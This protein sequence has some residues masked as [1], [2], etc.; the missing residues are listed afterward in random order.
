VSA[1]GSPL[2]PADVERIAQLAH[3]ALAGA[4]VRRIRSDRE[5]ERVLVITLRVPGRTV[6]LL[7]DLRPGTARVHAT[8]TLPPA[9]GSPP[10]FVQL[11][12][13]RLE[14]AHLL[15]VEPVAGDRTLR[16]T[17]ASTEAEGT[18][19]IA[20]GVTPPC[21][22]FTDA[23][24]VSRGALPLGATLPHSPAPEAVRRRP[25]RD[26]LTSAAD[27]E[28]ASQRLAAEFDPLV[29]AHRIQRLRTL[30]RRIAHQ[31]L[32]RMRRRL[33]AIERDIDAIGAADTLRHEAD[34]LNAFRA[35]YARGATTLTLPDWLRE[36][37]P[38]VISLDP[39]RPLDAQI[40]ARYRRARRLARG[41]EIA[42]RRH[43]AT[44]QS[45]AALE[46][47][48]CEVESATQSESLAPLLER[49]PATSPRRTSARADAAPARLPWHTFASS[50]GLP[51][52]VG[53]SA[54]D[55]DRLT[56]QQARGNDV[57][58]HVEDHTGSHVVIRAPKGAQ[59]PRRTLE[60]AALLAAHY[61]DARGEAVVAVRWT[62]RKHVRKPRG[63]PPGAV[64]VAAARTI[65]IRYDPER[66]ETLLSQGREADPGM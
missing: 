39:A 8:E 62:E 22:V 11:L 52:L 4:A 46:Q 16:L 28:E 55:N 25:L 26:A 50:D 30:A 21:A 6:P 45:I 63:A 58:L 60:E 36:N 56:F 15:A 37:E 23:D 9:P 42:L 18:L 66:L 5:D 53:R 47:I 51:I 48:L 12:R 20:L 61:S 24:G 2:S 34:L 1:M 29:E 40:E 59:M 33:E 41:G 27:F 13:H 3:A 38:I 57:W 17:F 65:D 49:L 32:R 10:L 44:E 14:A 35:R 7:I 31:A 54:R 64:T 43:T 19:T